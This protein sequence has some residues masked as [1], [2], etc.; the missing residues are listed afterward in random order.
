MSL[1][2][3]IVFCAILIASNSSLQ[4]MLNLQASP[5]VNVL[6]CLH[7]LFPTVTNVVLV[8]ASDGWHTKLVNKCHQQKSSVC[9]HDNH[10]RLVWIRFGSFS[11][12]ICI[13]APAVCRPCGSP[14]LGI[15][16]NVVPWTYTG[17]FETVSRIGRNWSKKKKKIKFHTSSAPVF[18]DQHACALT[19]DEMFLCIHSF[20]VIQ[21]TLG[22]LLFPF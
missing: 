10:W 18:V 16:A 22:F 7:L 8:F 3:S 11:K 19:C 13:S 17:L 12:Q 20:R 14:T 5:V 4:A 6:L 15:P 21:K 9:V 2:T 1:L